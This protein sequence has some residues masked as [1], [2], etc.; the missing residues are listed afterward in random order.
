M[1]EMTPL[2]EQYNKLK[3]EHKDEILLFRLGDFY[4]MFDS[5]AKEVSRLINLTLT[6]RGD[7]PMCGIPYHAAKVYIARL[8]RLGKK[9]AIAE[10]IGEISPGGGLT[11]RKV[12]EVITPGTVVDDDY[13]DRGSNNFLAALSVSK[14]RAGFAF[15]DVSTSEFLATS[16][17]AS[18]MAENFSKEL[19]RASPKELLLPQSLRDNNDIKIALGTAQNILVSYYPDW[20]FSCESSFSRLTRQFKTKNLSSFSL[21]EN[22]AEVAPAGFLLDYLDKTT[23]AELSHIA[24]IKV[25]HDTDYVL[26]DDSSRRNL[27]ILQNMRDGSSKCTL[28]ECVNYT[29]TAMGNRA[30]RQWLSFPLVDIKKIAARQNHVKMFFDDEGLLAFCRDRLSQILDIE[31]LAGRVAMQKAHAKDLVALAESLKSWLEIQA[32][33]TPHDFGLF[34]EDGA[35]FIIDLIGRAICDDPATSLTEGRI[36]RAG[37]SKE[38]DHFK[39]V[40]DNFNKI[41]DEYLAQEI[42]QTG[43]QNLKIKHNALAGYFIEVTRGKV[44][45]VPSHFIIRRA[46]TN[47]DRYTTERLQELE[48]ELNGASASIMETEK[49][50]FLETRSKI[51]PYVSYL[52]NVARSIAYIDVSASFAHAAKLGR[53][54]MPVIDGS[55]DFEIKAGRHP[56]VESRLPSGEFVPNDI[57]I[58]AKGRPSFLLITGPNMAGK[59]TYLRQSALIALLAQTGSFVPASAAKIGFVDKIFCRVGASDNLARGESTFLVEMS[60]TARILRGASERSLVIMDEVGRGTSTEDGLSIAWAVSEHLLNNIGCRALFAT[61]YHELTRMEHSSMRLLCMDVKETDGSVVFMRKIK[62]GASENSYGI[63]VA[64]LAGIP[65]SVIDRASQILR[66]LQAL[67]SEKPLLSENVPAPQEME[68]ALGQSAATAPGLFSDEE[69]VLDE[70]LSADV[71]NLTPMSALQLISRWKKSLS[72]R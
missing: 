47:A 22:S 17:P 34:D 21:D 45:K 25:Y 37:Y 14:G 53:W 4:E 48:R 61:H 28:L 38:L 15:V 58:V 41:L 11:E 59:S 12:V 13:L 10:Q 60:E 66:R 26:M 16:W 3:N 27:E 64:R 19:D 62:E 32:A 49:A 70:I 39:E 52:M 7:A 63:H 20:H 50:L 57:E 56:V 43:I 33:L 18:K 51:E 23:N 44:D 30:V 8:L 72:G 46:L 71:D 31:R 54:V 69:I 6:H 55:L 40:H 42:Q 67:A 1:A 2:M 36:I 5:D 24:G 35:R 9:L 68:Q 65:Q 29:L